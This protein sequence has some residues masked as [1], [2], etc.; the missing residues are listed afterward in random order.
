M[1]TIYLQFFSEHQF[2]SVVLLGVHLSDC[3]SSSSVPQVTLCFL[4]CVVHSAASVVYYIHLLKW[5]GEKT[6]SVKYAPKMTNHIK[7]LEFSFRS[8]IFYYR[9]TRTYPS[10]YDETK[11]TAMPCTPPPPPPDWTGTLR[12]NLSMITDHLPWRLTLISHSI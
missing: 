7:F 10:F 2:C 1:C 6:V 11:S 5:L 9:A 12:I 8:K 3:L 4:L